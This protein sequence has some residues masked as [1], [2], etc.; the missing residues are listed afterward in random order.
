MACVASLIRASTKFV[1]AASADN[2]SSAFV[3]VGSI[4]AAAGTIAL[5][6]IKLRRIAISDCLLDLIETLREWNP[7]PHD[8]C[9]C[10]ACSPWHT[11]SEPPWLW[12]FNGSNLVP[13]GANLWR[14]IAFLLF[15]RLLRAGKISAPQPQGSRQDN[16]GTDQRK[17][18]GD[19][20]KLTHAGRS[21]VLRQHKTTK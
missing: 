20:Q 6:P 14:F 8:R 12:G 5:V 9:R 16:Q 10:D 15:S 18:D 11:L 19:R 1:A 17:C 2:T 13:I 4:C 21:P 7:L 3:S